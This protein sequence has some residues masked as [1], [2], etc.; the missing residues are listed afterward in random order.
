MRNKSLVLRTL[1]GALALLLVASAPSLRAEQRD[2]AVI[3]LVSAIGAL[4]RK[5]CVSSNLSERTRSLVISSQRAS[6]P[7]TW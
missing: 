7:S 2:K 4:P 1:T 6:R 5:S 3:G